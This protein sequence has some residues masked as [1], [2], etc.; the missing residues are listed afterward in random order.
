MFYHLVLKY[1]VIVISNEPP[2][3][4]ENARLRTVPFK[5]LTDQ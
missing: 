4:N 5:P 3:K 2:C 1:T